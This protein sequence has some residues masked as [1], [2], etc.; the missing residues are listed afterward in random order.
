M[1][2]IFDAVIS[3]LED[4]PSHYYQTNFLLQTQLL[5]LGKGNSDIYQRLIESTEFI[6]R[7]SMVRLVD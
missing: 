5:A 6:N 2:E 1:D 3:R 7:A 4:S